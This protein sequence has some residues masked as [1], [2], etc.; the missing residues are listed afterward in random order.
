MP[1]MDDARWKELVER[2]EARD[3]RW[4]ERDA[5]FKGLAQRWEERDRR[6]E[7]RD[8]EHREFMREMW[9]RIEVM[10]IRQQAAYERMI[11]SLDAFTQALW[12][13]L[14]RLSEGPHPAS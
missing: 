13:M 11:E 1:D 9:R 10:D 5:W 2:W 4:E 3:R 6:W 12:K 7:E 14:D 8:R